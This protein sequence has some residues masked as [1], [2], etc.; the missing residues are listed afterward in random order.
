MFAI[1]PRRLDEYAKADAQSS[2]PAPKVTAGMVARSIELAMD[3][4]AEAVARGALAAA[5]DARVRITWV[6]LVLA[7]LALPALAVV[8]LSLS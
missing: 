4:Y 3:E 6:P 8:A 7:I 2:T 1:L 5:P